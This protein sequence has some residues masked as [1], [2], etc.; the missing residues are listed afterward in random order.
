MRT[1]RSAGG[2]VLRRLPTGIV[3]ILIIKDSYDQWAFPKGRIEPGET[4]VQ[5]ARRETCEETHLDQLTLVRPLGHSEFWFVDKWEQPGQKVHKYIN[6]FLFEADGNAVA[7]PEGKQRV[8]EVRW[9]PL[10]QLQQTVTY[11]TLQPI[12]QRVLAVLAH[13]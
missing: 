7:R 11:E 9:I 12:V 13:D 2:V 3:Q 8:K 5:A 6:H 4:P 10:E 1:E